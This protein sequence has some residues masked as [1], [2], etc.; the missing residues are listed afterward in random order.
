MVATPLSEAAEAT[1]LARLETAFQKR[2]DARAHERCHVPGWRLLD[3]LRQAPLNA[4]DSRPGGPEPTASGVP[5]V[6]DRMCRNL[7]RHVVRSRAGP[8]LRPR[9]PDRIF[10]SDLRARGDWTRN[11]LDRTQ[12]PDTTY[13]PGLTASLRRTCFGATFRWCPLTATR[14]PTLPQSRLHNRR[15]S[16]RHPNR[17]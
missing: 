14:R 12:G 10:V 7:L 13:I 8:S 2:C 1:R 6:D 11:G 15:P 4:A 17:T 16:H 9:S 5:T 3:L